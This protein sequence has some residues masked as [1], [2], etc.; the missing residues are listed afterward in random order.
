MTLTPRQLLDIARRSRNLVTIVHESNEIGFVVRLALNSADNLGVIS[1]FR[2]GTFNRAELEEFVNALGGHPELDLGFVINP[3][4]SYQATDANPYE[5]DSLLDRMAFCLSVFL[6]GIRHFEIVAPHPFS[7]LINNI[8]DEK[9]RFVEEQSFMLSLGEMK[10]IWRKFAGPIHGWLFNSSNEVAPEGYGISRR[11]WDEILPVRTY[12]PKK[13]FESNDKKLLDMANKLLEK[14]GTEKN[15][16]SKL[17]RQS[18]RIYKYFS[19]NGDIVVNSDGMNQ[20]S[21]IVSGVH[22]DVSERIY[23]FIA[24]LLKNYDI[25]ITQGIKSAPIL[26]H[27][28]EMCKGRKHSS[29]D[30]WRYHPN[31]KDL[32]L[33]TKGGS[34]T[35][36]FLLKKL[37][38]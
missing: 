32:I 23:Y 1:L 14:I 16:L 29:H 27:V 24:Y 17:V 22:Y 9:A 34:N 36:R 20:Y 3:T 19:P 25:S 28:H 13:E 5:D 15:S 35:K 4:N 12:V 31:I 8:F 33:E 30:I 7:L 38:T 10:M 18:G 6:I 21:L 26:E 2:R 37:I 11:R